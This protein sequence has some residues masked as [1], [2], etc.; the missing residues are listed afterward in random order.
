MWEEGEDATSLETL[1]GPLGSVHSDGDA[2]RRRAFLEVARG[3]NFSTIA[4]LELLEQCTLMDQG[5]AQDGVVHCFD[6]KHL[7]KRLRER[8]KSD[9]GVRVGGGA[10]ITGPT[11]RRLAQ[12]LFPGRS[13]ESLLTPK[14]R[15]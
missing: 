15:Y 10:A 11:L 14:D 9:K 6:W 8:V 13:V 5:C 3:S 2:G 12:V 4:H 7:I 1:V